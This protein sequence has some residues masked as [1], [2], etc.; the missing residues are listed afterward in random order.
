MVV[1]DAK[2]GSA[3]SQ[4]TEIWDGETTVQPC[5]NPSPNRMKRIFILA[6]LGLLAILAGWQFYGLSSAVQKADLDPRNYRTLTLKNQIEVLLIQDPAATKAAASLSVGVGQFQDPADYSG[7]AHYLEHMLF[8]G[9]E[10]YP[11]PA[12]FG[13]FLARHGGF[14]NAYTAFEETNYHFA[15]QAEQFAGALE[16]FSEF[17]VHPLLNG[18][19]A[20][21]EL[22]AVD[23]EHQKNLNNDYR[24]TYQ[25]LAENA[26]PQHPLHNFGTGS[27]KSIGGGHDAAALGAKLKKFYESH[28]SANRMKLV[29]LAPV[30]LDQQAEL[31]ETYFSRIP[32]KNLVD[33]PYSQIPLVAAPL[34][35]QIQV[36]PIQNL[37]S[38]QFVFEVDSQWH[39]RQTR[40]L[41]VLGHLL[42]HEAQHSLLSLLK[43]KGWAT[44]LQAGGMPPLKGTGIFTLSLTLTPEGL[45]QVDPITQLLFAYLD[46]LARQ[47]DL[48]EYYAELRAMA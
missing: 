14:S 37:R 48:S 20:A 5:F 45:T 17:F 7:L 22:Q 30:D 15:L 41:E 35:R 3:N 21:Q 11:D 39:Y 44:E 8:M 38:L 27:L 43:E 32:N 9:T 18:T 25:V 46:L 10:A 34:P 29:L 42:G 40:P 26:N 47:P 1:A 28:Y 2:Q 4:Q 6:P 16:R 13:D 23:S 36:Q 12:E 19:Y 24:R 31:A 33:A